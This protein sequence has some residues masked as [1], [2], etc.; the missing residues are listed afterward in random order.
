M[1]YK[2]IFAVIGCIRYEG[3]RF[4]GE[5]KLVSDLFSTAQFSTQENTI[6]K[7]F[8]IKSSKTGVGSGVREWRMVG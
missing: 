4:L 6:P 8:Y 1:N 5:K 7:T 3:K 2:K